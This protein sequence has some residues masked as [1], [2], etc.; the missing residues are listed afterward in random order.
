[1]ALKKYC[2]VVNGENIYLD[3]GKVERY[4]FFTER[5]VEAENP[6]IAADLAL[7]HVE[8]ELVK[9][10][11]LRNRLEDPPSLLI[12]EIHEVSSFGDN[13][14]PGKGFSFYPDPAPGK[15]GGEIRH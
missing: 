14:V 9:G 15:G 1:M 7:V 10:N 2:V 11:R 5:W 8:Q 12:D 13:I 6:K 4:G 3:M